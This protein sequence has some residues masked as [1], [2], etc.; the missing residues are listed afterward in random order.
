MSTLPI[1]YDRIIGGSWNE[2]AAS[3]AVPPL[4][5]PHVDGVPVVAKIHAWYDEATGLY[6]SGRLDATVKVLPDLFVPVD[7]KTRGY[8]PKGV[9][10]A[11]E[12]Q[13]DVYDL[14]LDRSGY[15]T[16]GYGL[17]IYFIP[18]AAELD[19]GLPLAVE[20]QKVDTD[21]QRALSWIARA[22]EVL[23]MESPP[24]PTPDCALCFWVA[25]TRP[26]A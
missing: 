22:A 25:K 4:L 6:V 20:V 15:Q 18:E 14:L 3:G 2:Y 23:A 24:P 12:L 26:A 1:K 10:P 9:H 7:H 17:L 16:A 8:P 13:L 5:R 19:Q 21:R 11:Y